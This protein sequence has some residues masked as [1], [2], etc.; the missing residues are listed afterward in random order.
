MAR[1]KEVALVHL[2]PASGVADDGIADGRRGEQSDRVQHDEGGT[3]VGRS[4][5]RPREEQGKVS[6]NRPRVGEPE[7]VR[8]LQ[9]NFCAKNLFAELQR[10]QPILCTAAAGSSPTAAVDPYRLT[11]ALD[12]GAH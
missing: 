4:D 11:S 12:S 9:C 10:H 2:C 1:G 5:R 7:L 3:S 6:I 8:L